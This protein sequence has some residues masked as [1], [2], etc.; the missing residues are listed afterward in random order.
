MERLQEKITI[1]SNGTDKDAWLEAIEKANK[2]I[3]D[4]SF[5]ERKDYVRKR[6][7]R[8]REYR[9]AIGKQTQNTQ[10]AA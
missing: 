4:M 1:Y 3:N 2:Q 5:E 8:I 9:E 7:A 10:E 6:L